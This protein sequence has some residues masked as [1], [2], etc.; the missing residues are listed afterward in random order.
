[1]KRRVRTK[2]AQRELA[3]CI[4]AL[5]VLPTGIETHPWSLAVGEN[6]SATH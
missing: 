6:D 5:K 2:Q 1:M 4:E 3:E